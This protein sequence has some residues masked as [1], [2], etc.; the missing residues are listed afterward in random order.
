LSDIQRR[1]I[2]LFDVRG[3]DR[4]RASLGQMASGFSNYRRQLD[5]TERSGNAVNQQLRALGTTL[6][7]SLAGAGI[8]GTMQM[9]R[10]LG[11]F[12]AKL[13][14]IQA[15]GTGPG[16]LD[17]TD[18]QIDQLGQRLIDVSNK[19]TQPIADLQQGVLTLYS[20]IGDV[21]E[22]EAAAMMEEISKIA[23][24]SQSN[25]EDTTNAVLGMLNAFGRG[26]GELNKFGDQFQTVIRL[27]AGMPGSTYAG[28]LGVLSGSAA[29]AR[30][31]PEQMGALSIGATRFGGSAATNMTYLAQL[32]TYLENPTTVKERSAFASIGLNKQQLRTMPGWDILMKV[33]TAVNQRGGVG[34]TPGMASASDEML[35]QMDEQ[36]LTTQQ[37]G[38]TGGGSGLLQDL[39]GRMQSRRMAAILSRLM[40]PAQV[41]GTKNQTLDDYLQQVT[42]STGSVDRAMDKAMDYRRINQAANAMHNLGI[43]IGTSL[44]PL[45]QYPARGF[46][47]TISAFNN[48]HWK[49]PGTHISGQTAEVAGGGVGAFF[50]LR[51]L[52]GNAAAGRVARGVPLAAMGLD[53]LSGDTQRGHSPLNPLYVV[54]VYN[55]GNSFRGVPGTGLVANEAGVIAE[56][57][58]N[59]YK[60]SR[61]AK[62]RRAGIAGL[63]AAVGAYMLYDAF[64]QHQDSVH[65][66]RTDPLGLTHYLTK[67]RFGVHIPWVGTVGGG[68]ELQH[69]GNAREREIIQQLKA[70]QISP[71][72]AERRLRRAASGDQLKLAGVSRVVGKADVNVTITDK[73][74]NKRG[75]AHVATDLWPDFT[76][77]APQTKAKPVTR[78]SNQ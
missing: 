21:P 48:Q 24:T 46:T 73:Q 32:M 71:D 5:M 70:H 68:T 25:I 16:G 12:Q 19:T 78:R 10:N 36:G 62:F 9:V 69:S 38:I 65:A 43:E 41:A 1:V 14:E 2:T 20:T 4:V 76:T 30:F 47:S 63:G 11:E 77:P 42:K 60:Q 27:S 17:I 37:A 61:G 56:S 54:V 33:L 40:T 72:E 59:Y 6:R 74:G 44:S 18:R 13:G 7:Y 26:T 55:T 8:Y 31:T 23:I 35:S 66:A 45:L 53:A 75:S 51:A 22:N 64:N 28:K 57:G 34:I 67:R 39:F 50:L 3:S 29:L 58:P 52:R 15:I 49:V